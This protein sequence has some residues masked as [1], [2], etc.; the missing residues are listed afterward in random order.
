MTDLIT[1]AHAF[2]DERDVKWSPT[3]IGE[4]NES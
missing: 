4:Q 3:S 1:L 2:G